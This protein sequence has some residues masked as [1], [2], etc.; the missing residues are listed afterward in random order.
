MIGL[1][2]RCATKTY[3][4]VLPSIGVVLIYLD[5][6]LSVIQRAICSIIRHTPAH[7]LREIILVDDHSSHSRTAL[8]GLLAYL[9][10]HST[11]SYSCYSFMFYLKKTYLAS[12]TCTLFPSFDVMLVYV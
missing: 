3:P 12:E 5:E 10:G 1:K 4:E 7:L 8:P 6:A 9:A 2:N 11:C